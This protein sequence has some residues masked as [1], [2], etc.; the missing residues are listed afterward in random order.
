MS[1]S[2]IETI[3]IVRREHEYLVPV[4]IGIGMSYGI[5]VLICCWEQ[6]PPGA[7]GAKGEWKEA[8]RLDLDRVFVGLYRQSFDNV[9][10]R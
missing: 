3:S 2:R 9:M 1:P 5:N 6:E 10:F 7:V 8:S 4:E